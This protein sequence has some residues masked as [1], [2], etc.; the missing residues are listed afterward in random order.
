MLEGRQHRGLR[1]V[2]EAD[3]GVADDLLGV[4]LAM[5]L[6]ERFT[7]ALASRSLVAGARS[8]AARLDQ[9]GAVQ[10]VG[11]PEARGYFEAVGAP[12]FAANS[13]RLKR[14]SRFVSY[15]SKLRRDHR[16]SG[17]SRLLLLL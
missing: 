6:L 14:P 9:V 17:N 1:D 7:R 2:P 3:D 5:V 15:P 16:H 4:R 11:G 8:S 13:W 10:P 12:P